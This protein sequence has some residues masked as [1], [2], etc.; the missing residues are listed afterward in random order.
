V[1]LV[2]LLGA[3]SIG[4]GVCVYVGTWLLDWCDITE[5]VACVVGNIF[6]LAPGLLVVGGLG[7]LATA[8]DWVGLVAL[9][10][11]VAAL[12]FVTV[13]TVGHIIWPLVA[14]FVVVMVLVLK[15]PQRL[16]RYYG[17]LHE[18]E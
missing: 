15:E 10:L 17:L 3:A 13:G 12:A 8:R 14:L 1:A 16:L 18:V 2:Q 5:P 11:W 9:V 7:L 4:A 6:L